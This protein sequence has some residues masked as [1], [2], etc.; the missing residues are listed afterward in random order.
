MTML[1]S[2]RNLSVACTLSLMVACAPGT[3]A[4]QPDDVSGRWTTDAPDYA[5]IAQAVAAARCRRPPPRARSCSTPRTARIPSASYA[6]HRHRRHCRPRPGSTRPRARRPRH[7]WLLN[8]LELAVSQIV[9]TSRC[10]VACRR[11]GVDRARSALAPASILDARS[12]DHGRD[13]YSVGTMVGC[14]FLSFLKTSER[15]RSAY[16]AI[17]SGKDPPELAGEITPQS[18]RT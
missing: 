6:A 2:L 7:Y 8:K 17:P 4:D 12:Q 14:S 15:M 3:V 9:D 5:V 13:G 11:G 16:P 1:I 18:R 10:T